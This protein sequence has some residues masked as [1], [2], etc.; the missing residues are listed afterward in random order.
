MAVKQRQQ[1]LGPQRA[2][3]DGARRHGL[4]AH[5][6]NEQL[7]GVAARH[8]LRQLPHLRMMASPGMEG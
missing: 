7:R 8:A 2:S 3:L 4:L 1:P 5:V 6:P